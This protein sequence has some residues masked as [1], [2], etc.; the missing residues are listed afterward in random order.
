MIGLKQVGQFH[1]MGDDGRDH[2]INVYRESASRNEGKESIASDTFLVTGD[3]R[4]VAHVCEGVF[5]VH[6]TGLTLR[7]ER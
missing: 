4:E 3:G 1:A 6:G 2:V 7:R 5:R